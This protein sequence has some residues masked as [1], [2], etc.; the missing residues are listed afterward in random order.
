MEQEARQEGNGNAMKPIGKILLSMSA[1][2]IA[3]Y[4][5]YGSDRAMLIGC[6]KVYVIHVIVILALTV[7]SF[8]LEDD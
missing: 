6:V 2:A 3:A 1:F 5:V 4:L 7:T 8:V